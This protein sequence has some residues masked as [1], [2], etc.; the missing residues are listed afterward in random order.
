MKVFP[1]N[2]K[3]FSDFGNRESDDA[4]TQCGP[5]VIRYLVD[6]VISDMPN[7]C[8]KGDTTFNNNEFVS[9]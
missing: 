9:L 8:V 1:S 3:T 6:R 7:A 5:L 4:W 2:T